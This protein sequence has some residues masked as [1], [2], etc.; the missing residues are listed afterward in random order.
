MAAK[1]ESVLRRMA[2]KDQASTGQGKSHPFRRNWHVRE[3][4]R[5]LFDV[6]RVSVPWIDGLSSLQFG[7]Q[8]EPCR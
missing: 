8:V 4:P 3:T 1:Q 7:V 5:V 6:K 2:H